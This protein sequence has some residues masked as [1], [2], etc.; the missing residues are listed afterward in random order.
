MAN[1]TSAEKAIRKTKRRTKINV[2]RR[3]IIKSCVKKVEELVTKGDKAAAQQALKTAQSELMRGV[4][5][6]VLKLNAASRKV[7]R[8]AARIKKLA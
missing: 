1:H 8:L 5:K 2:S 6:N 3:S 4:T 7:S